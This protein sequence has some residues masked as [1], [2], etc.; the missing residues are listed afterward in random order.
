MPGGI[1]INFCE[2]ERPNLIEM[3]D[4]CEFWANFTDRQFKNA[5]ILR[6]TVSGYYVQVNGAEGQIIGVKDN[7]RNRDTDFSAELD[8]RRLWVRS[9]EG[10]DLKD[11]GIEIIGSIVHLG[12]IIATEF[13]GQVISISLGN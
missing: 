11:I 4:R 2:S 6:T 3:I 7:T 9:H 12:N 10:L 8:Y 5:V 1:E 13:F